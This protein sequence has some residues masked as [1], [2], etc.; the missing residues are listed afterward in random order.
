MGHVLRMV[1][2]MVMILV[3]G[4]GPYCPQTGKELQPNMLHNMKI[5]KGAHISMFFALF[6][7]LLVL[8]VVWS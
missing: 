7:V 3:E 1:C 4:K 5:I 6:G 8:N 2:W